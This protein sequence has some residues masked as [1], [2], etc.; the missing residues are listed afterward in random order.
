MMWASTLMNADILS[1]VMSSTH[2]AFWRCLLL[3]TMDTGDML[4]AVN[5]RK[6]QKDVAGWKW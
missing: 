1:T 5:K 2:S 4:Y 6:P 3:R